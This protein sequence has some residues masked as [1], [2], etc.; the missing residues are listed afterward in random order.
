MLRRRWM[1][2]VGVL[3]LL[4]IVSACSGDSKNDGASPV[5]SRNDGETI[6]LTMLRD[7]ATI[8]EEEFANLIEA[9]VQENFPHIT[10]DMNRDSG[11]DEGVSNLLV[12]GEFPDLMFATYPRIRAHRLTDTAYGLNEF[13]EKHDV[14]LNKFDPAA[15]ETSRVYGGSD[16][17]IYALPFS[18]NFLALFYNVDIFEN[19]N[20][21]FPKEGMTWDELI[22]LGRQLTREVDGVQYK[23]IGA[24]PGISDLSTQLSLARVDGET[25]RANLTTEGW[26]KAFEV[27]KAINEIPGN[28][29]AT[30]NEFLQD[31]VVAM[32]PSYDAR[33]A[34]LELLH[35]TPDEFNWDITQF[36][37]FPERP[38]VS[39]ASSGHFL[40]VSSLTDY[41]EE[42]F[43]IIDLLTSR[44]N[45]ILITEHGRFTSLNDQEIKDMYG[46]NMKSL[47]GKNIKAVFQS[48]F[49]PPYPP[50]E[51]DSLVTPH[52]NDA[53]NKVIDGVLDIN[54][55]LRQAEEAS[56]RDIQAARAGKE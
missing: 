1:L 7:G 12:S 48:A 26:Q 4:F 16:N 36:P 27:I 55:A 23:G 8:S 35:G 50:T 33:I 30:L 54:T 52:L 13:I 14:D 24:V 47:E 37:S 40:M 34:A 32:V 9:P 20:V 45:Q 10:I 56:N 25:L 51:Y 3:I 31:K 2:S 46:I 43:Q 19:F 39:L 38:N 17:E 29:R 42:A 11:G 49:A 28:T 18:L 5:S 53:I 6:H 22:A 21:P 44:D 15:M 41:K